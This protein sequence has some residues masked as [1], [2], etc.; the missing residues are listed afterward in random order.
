MMPTCERFRTGAQVAL[1]VKMITLH[2]D[3]VLSI[4]YFYNERLN[5]LRF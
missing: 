2:L 5:D 3:V 1:K 4:F